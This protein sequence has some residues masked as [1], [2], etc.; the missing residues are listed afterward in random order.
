MPLCL[1][2]RIYVMEVWIDDMTFNRLVKREYFAS[3][4]AAARYLHAEHRLPEDGPLEDATSANGID[5]NE[6]LRWSIEPVEIK[7]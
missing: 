4:T 1:L 6:G 5:D 3:F 7:G 2:D